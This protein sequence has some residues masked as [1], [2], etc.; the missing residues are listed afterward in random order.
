[1]V[2][3]AHHTARL[4]AVYHS[5]LF[6]KLP[7]ERHTVAVVV[8]IAVEPYCPHGHIGRKQLRKLPVHKAIVR[9]PVAQRESRPVVCPVRPPRIIG[10]C[11]VEMRVVQM[12]SEIFPRTRL[13]QL[14]QHVAP[15]RRGID[16]VVI[17]LPG[18]PHRK[19]VVMPAG[20]AHIPRS[21]TR[22]GFGSCPHRNPQDRSLAR[23]WHTPRQAEAVSLRY[24]S[25]CP[26]MLYMPQWIKCRS[27]RRQILPA[28]CALPLRACTPPR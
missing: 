1:M 25:P 6:F 2:V 10:A 14:A 15:E 24:H 4:Q 12:K 18:V 16:Y 17:T 22:Y 8:P 9:F 20:K 19:T 13:R 11:P 7:V 26:N 23:P 5:V 3:V 28:I 27:G 21:R